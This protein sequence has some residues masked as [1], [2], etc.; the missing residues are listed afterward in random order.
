LRSALWR[1]DKRSPE[2]SARDAKDIGVLLLESAG[3]LGRCVRD[4]AWS[5]YRLARIPDIRSRVIEHCLD[6]VGLVQPVVAIELVRLLVCLR[7]R[8]A[9]PKLLSLARTSDSGAV[10]RNAILG[11]ARLGAVRELMKLR[12]GPGV[13]EDALAREFACASLR[14]PMPTPADRLARLVRDGAWIL[15]RDFRFCL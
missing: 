15:G 10:R 4:W 11:L 2:L 8:A 7:E 5:L 14:V 6:R 13:T 3:T 12:D 9:L 1:L